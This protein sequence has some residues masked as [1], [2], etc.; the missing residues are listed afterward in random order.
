VDRISVLLADDHAQFRA[1]AA[2][3]LGSEYQVVAAVGDGQAVLDEAA[4]L[5]PD[6]LVLD[7][8]MPVLNGI[9]AARRLTA[10]GSCTKIVFLTVHQDP[11]SVQ[12]ALAAGA[13][14]YVVKCRLASDLPLAVREALAGRSFTSP[15]I[16]FEQT[17]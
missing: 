10:A 4:R 1:A 13:V 17:V 6:V 9:E 2:R 5:K 16:S 11:D 12:A 7:I 3:L 8:S 14:G 15:S